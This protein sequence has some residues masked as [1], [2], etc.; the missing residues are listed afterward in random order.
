MFVLILLFTG[1]Q[2]AAIM[3]DV[4]LE[5]W[6]TKSESEQENPNLFYTF[7]AL[8]LTATVAGFVRRNST[9]T[10]RLKTQTPNRYEQLFSS[11]SVFEHLPIYIPKL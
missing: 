9:L 10:K 7:M 4:T 6:S 8:T 5:E 3:S 2:V 11:T 1:G